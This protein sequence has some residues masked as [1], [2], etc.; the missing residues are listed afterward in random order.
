M[1]RILTL[2]FYLLPYLLVSQSGDVNVSTKKPD[3]DSNFIITYDQ[4]ILKT[5]IINKS[6]NFEITNKKTDQTT[7]FEPNGVSNLGFGFNYKSIGLSLAFIPL[8][9]SQTDKYGKTSK[10]DIRGNFFTRKIGFDVRLQLYRG[11]YISN[12]SS[13]DPTFNPDSIYP[14]R[15]DIVTVSIGG[16]AFYIFNH[17]KFS[18]KSIYA[19]NEWQIKSAGSFYTGLTYSLFGIGADYAIAPEIEIDS[20]D[21]G[22]Y[23][24]QASF[25]SLGIFGGY[26]YNLIIKKH[27]FISMGMAPGITALRIRLVDGNG[28][29]VSDAIRPAGTFNFQFA[30]GFNSAKQFGGMTIQ[31]TSAGFTYNSGEGRFDFQTG[32]LRLYYGFRFL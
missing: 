2:S 26:M 24:K 18:F 16:S 30:L 7:Q 10:L 20:I 6:N 13:L 31:S 4:L 14:Q 5:Y 28:R 22:D 9:K 3:C 27:G 19:N 11:F 23:F 25:V 8:N 29:L 1:K 17:D 12:M 15:P 32:S 21:V